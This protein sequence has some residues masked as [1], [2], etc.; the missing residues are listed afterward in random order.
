MFGLCS[1][2]FKNRNTYYA[3]LIINII[4]HV[5]LKIIASIFYR[6]N[7]LKDDL[8]TG[9]IFNWPHV[10]DTLCLTGSLWDL[11]EGSKHIKWHVI[12]DRASVNLLEKSS[13]I[14]LSL[15]RPKNLT[16][17]Q[18]PFIVKLL[19][20]HRFDVVIFAKSSANSQPFHNFTNLALCLLVRP[21]VLYASAHQGFIS[22]INR[23]TV[24][25]RPVSVAAFFSLAVQKFLASPLPNGVRPELKIDR[26]KRNEGSA[27]FR[28][29]SNGQQVLGVFPSSLTFQFDW[30]IDQLATFIFKMNTRW[31]FRCAVFVTEKQLI[32]Y[33]DLTN[34]ARLRVSL[35]CQSNIE[36]VISILRACV[37]VVT[38]DSG[39][40]HIGNA[41]NIPVFYIKNPKVPKFDDNYV[42]TEFAISLNTT[43]GKV[44]MNEINSQKLV[45]YI[46]EK[47]QSFQIHSSSFT[48]LIG[49]ELL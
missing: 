6:K 28:E 47:M 12:V 44:Q 20:R 8:R 45:E 32:R 18:R 37:C 21:R 26:I 39:G 7:I 27:I 43:S 36:I 10:G 31:N 29:I 1:E 46:E 17:F 35:V 3:F 19:W 49:N 23:P 2:S 9:M 16:L 33:K 42:D 30:P 4:F 48:E 24:V 11:V 14:P 38:P 40:R 41:A 22:L 13:L 34:D 25:Q 5:P 15:D